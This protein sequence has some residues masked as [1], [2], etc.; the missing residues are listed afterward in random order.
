MKI[1]S[2][3]INDH[4][5]GQKPSMDFWAVFT[6]LDTS[7]TTTPYDSFIVHAK[8]EHEAWMLAMDRFEQAHADVLSSN[9]NLLIR[10]DA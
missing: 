6:E 4:S 3:F 7:Q 9:F 2:T 8:T 5:K 1:R 10:R